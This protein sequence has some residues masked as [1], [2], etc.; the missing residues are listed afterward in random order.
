[1][2]RY[3]GKR[4]LLMVPVL[5]G[6][7]LLIF[8]LLH[9]TPGDPARMQLG[10]LATEEE[11]LAQREKMGL[12][13]PLVI[14]F[15]RYLKNLVTDLDLGNSYTSGRPVTTEIF[16]R[17]PTTILLAVLS[18]CV[19]LIIGIPTGIL[20][21]VKQYS[22][23]DNVSM[24]VGLVGIS[25]PNFW[26][27][28]MLSLLFALKL[29]WLPASGFYGPKYWI[30]PALAIGINSAATVMR[31]T[32]SAMLEVIRQDYIRTARAKGQTERMV[33]IHHA[34]KNAM[35]PIIT[36]VGI[37][38]GVLLGGAMVTEQIFSIPGLGSYLVTAIGQRDYP[39]IQGG[40]LIMA[41]TSGFVN[42]AIDIIYGFVDP[43]IKSQYQKKKR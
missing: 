14:Q 35:I 17:Y 36:V 22:W 21:A 31:M 39:V 1:M 5:L 10:T 27:G 28:L 38:F 29:R 43:R 41:V 18:V 16:S 15:G 4:I 12:D 25:V 40:V 23:V 33:I 11:I 26:L 13:D 19:T 42:L 9:F 8:L 6:V 30:L 7:T 3:V 37:Q 34:L 24:T 20:S 32:R 2:G